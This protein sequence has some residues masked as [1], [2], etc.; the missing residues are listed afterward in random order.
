MRNVGA[1]SA[2]WALVLTDGAAAAAAVVVAR[3][4]PPGRSGLPPAKP[5]PV[6]AAAV[7]PSGS[8]FSADGGVEEPRYAGGAAKELAAA[9]DS[10]DSTL[11]RVLLRVPLAAIVSDPAPTVSPTLEGDNIWPCEARRS[12]GRPRLAAAAALPADWLLPLRRRGM[13]LSGLGELERDTGSDPPPRTAEEATP[14]AKGGTKGA[15]PISAPTGT[16]AGELCWLSKCDALLLA[17]MPDLELLRRMPMWKLTGGRP[18]TDTSGGA[19]SAP[20]AL[21]PVG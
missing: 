4:A 3:V 13:R 7:A 2:M 8:G 11:M 19:C 10:T 6:P 15:L 1:E 12:R 9:A 14:R 16:S 20:G 17:L 5:S 18:R 21:G